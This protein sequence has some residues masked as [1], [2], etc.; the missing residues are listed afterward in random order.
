MYDSPA[1][2]YEY[3]K[4]AY[5]VLYKHQLI[6]T[7]TA[8]NNAR[9]VNNV[10]ASL[11]RSAGL[12]VRAIQSCSHYQRPFKACQAKVR[13]TSSWESQASILFSTHTT[14]MSYFYSKNFRK[15][16]D[17]LESWP[18]TNNL[19][20]ENCES[21]AKSSSKTLRHQFSTKQ[22]CCNDFLSRSSHA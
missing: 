9:F 3:D 12:P 11:R 6:R 4:C 21:P 17:V 5:K 10:R 1:L 19:G 20:L 16:W 8:S 2:I 18:R 7:D 14:V 13:S 15:L 22:V